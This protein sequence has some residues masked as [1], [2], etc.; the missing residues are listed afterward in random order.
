MK[1]CEHFDVNTIPKLLIV[2]ITTGELLNL[3]VRNS[4]I[5]YVHEYCMKKR[6]LIN[7]KA[8]KTKLNSSD[9]EQLQ[10]NQQQHQNPSSMGKNFNLNFDL[11]MYD[12]FDDLTVAAYGPISNRT[13]YSMRTKARHN[14]QRRRRKRKLNKY[15]LGE[16]IEN[17][18]HINNGQKYERK[19]ANAETRLYYLVYFC[20]NFTTSHTNSQLYDQ[21]IEFL[22]YLK[23]KV[24]CSIEIVLISSDHFEEDYLKLIRKYNESNQDA[25]V[26]NDSASTAMSDN[27]SRPNHNEDNSSSQRQMYDQFSRL[28]LKF[29]CKWVKEKLYQKL[30]ITG[31]PW[32]SL[33]DANNGEILC[34]NLKI[35]ILNSQLREMIF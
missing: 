14:Q 17:L 27:S 2:D 11:D 32:F 7:L 4:L 34:E 8:S 12:I 16:L 30:H 29:S 33:I 26:K 28:A 20:S 15:L 9:S 19:T 25:N 21:I 5:E 18:I 3:N 1:V 23:E 13:N 35:F 6:E 24:E 10:Q 22:N 31:I